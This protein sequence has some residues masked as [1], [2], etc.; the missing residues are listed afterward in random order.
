MRPNTPH[1]VIT[2]EH[3]IVYG[4]HFYSSSN[5]QDS[6]YGIVHCLMADTLITNNIH[7]ET[8]RLLFRMMQYFYNCYVQNVEDDGEHLKLVYEEN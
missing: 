4:G 1:A 3:S 7:L 6:L 2:P 8:R 5:L